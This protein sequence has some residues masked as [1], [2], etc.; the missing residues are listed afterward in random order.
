MVQ[1]K[2]RERPVV[3]IV[4]SP[5][6][7]TTIL[8]D[9]LSVHPA[10]ASWYEPYYLWERFFPCIENDVWEVKYLNKNAK[11]RMRKEFEIFAEK[12]GKPIIADKLPAHSFNI[13]NIGRIFPNAKW[14]HILRDG[15]DVTLSIKKEWQ[16]RSEIVQRKSVVALAKVVFIMLKIQPY[17]RYRI[18]AVIYELR[19]RNLLTP[20]AYFN[21]SRWGGEAGWGPRF[22]GWKAYLQTH[23]TL[24]F[25]AMQWVKCVEA[26][27]ENW[28]GL[29]DENKI[30][31][32]YEDLLQKPEVTLTAV[33][34]TIGVKP[35]SEVFQ[36]MPTLKNNNFDKWR[37]EFA[38]EEI[39]DILPIL[40]PMLRETGYSL[41]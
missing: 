17:W 29:R 13:R 11:R 16:E 24:E 5:R 8:E 3:F 18:M 15:R 14:I 40:N 6:S 36:R 41:R 25:N 19:T 35:T 26:V 30:V 37:Q 32:R 38:P 22:P 34:E 7:G 4:G 21:K 23:S 20:S 2:K 33:F 28:P 10:I 12:S 31:I 1:V 39:K 9:I 27:R